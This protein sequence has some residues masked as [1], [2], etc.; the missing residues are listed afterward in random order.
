MLTIEPPFYRVRGSTVFRDHENPDQFHVL[1]A[2]P[3]LVDGFTMYK[4]R[5]DLTDNPDLDLTTARGGGLAFFDVAA[6]VPPLAGLQAE[7]AALSGRADAVVSPVLFRSGS[8]HAIIA[9]TEGDRLIEDLVQTT[10]AP[11]APPH[12]ATFALATSPEGATLLERAALGGNL[13]VGVAYELRFLALTPALHAVVTMDYERIYDHFAA[14]VGLTYY[15]VQAKFD[16]DL[17]WLVEHDLIRID[18]ISFTDAED[19]QRQQQTV[20]DLVAARIQADFFRTGIPPE[21]AP[22]AGGALAAMLGNLLGGREVT[23]ASALFVLKAKVEVVREEKAFELRYD[24][25]TAVELTHVSTGVLASMVAGGSAPAIHE[26][27]LDDPFFAVL[28]V[29]V[30]AVVNS[31]DPGGLTAVLVHLRKGEHRASIEFSAGAA[32]R[33]RFTVP[34]TDRR[35]DE[36]EAE[37]EF[38]FD[39]DVSGGEPVLRGGPIRT[40]SRALAVDPDRYV[41]FFRVRFVRF[42]VDAVQ[43][44]RSHVLVRQV[45]SDGTEIA[46]TALVLDAARPEALWRHHLPAGSGARVLVS[47]EWEDPAGARHAGQHAELSSGERDFLVLGPFRDV[48]RIAVVPAVDWST[49]VTNAEVEISYVDGDYAVSRTLSFLAGNGASAQSLE[50]PVLDPTR[51]G[52]RWRQVVFHPDGPH[53]TAWADA[54]SRIL[55]IGREAA[56]TGEVRLVW[57]GDAAGVLGLRVDFAVAGAEGEHRTGAFLR[58]GVDTE[59][60]VPVPLDASGRLRYRYEVR[61]VR[62]DAETLV[63]SATADSDLLVLQANG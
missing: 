14:S 62:A 5:R 35:D 2:P 55:V 58:A 22:G 21:P 18:I 16:L 63:R 7:V 39:T 36:Y 50:I 44:P 29:T 59:K 47:T 41:D 1:P 20:L 51:R 27:D 19:A 40:R 34:L 37:F 49:G 17:A 32:D 23:S 28:D 42:A 60:V 56:T 57:V 25:R 48:L 8:V 6:D 45:A 46:R 13:P 31:T 38:R 53:E 15:C 9:H 10:V 11:P 4:Y 3:S 52:Y 12:R 30:L 33:G 61:A 26:V 54:D 43:V 24:G